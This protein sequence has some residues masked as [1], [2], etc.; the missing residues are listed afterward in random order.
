MHPAP[1]GCTAVGR[2]DEEEEVDVEEEEA[3]SPSPSSSSSLSS[4]CSAQ[5]LV[6]WRRDLLLACRAPEPSQPLPFPKCHGRCPIEPVGPWP[7]QPGGDG[8][9][10]LGALGSGPVPVSDVSSCTVL[11]GP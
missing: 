10:Y 3:P 8:V 11:A 6:P 9:E 4:S 1:V 2:E 5:F 7:Q